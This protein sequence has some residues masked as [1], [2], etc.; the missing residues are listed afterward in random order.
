MLGIKAY[1]SIE[2]IPAKVDL[3][4][5]CTPA[6]TRAAASSASASQAGVKGAVV[7]SAGF[8]E[9]G[10]EG[11]KLW[12][13]DAHRGAQGQDA[14]HRPELPGHPEPAHRRERHVRQRH[15]EARQ[16][17]LPV[18]VGA[19]R[20]AVLDWSFREQVGFSALRFH[21]LDG[22]CGLGRP[23]RLLRQ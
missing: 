20:T 23:D 9:L 15:G 14:H 18:A 7:I 6:P 1:P 8:A 12:R 11:K 5:V 22:R 16:R 13:A 17:G 10:E 21:R 2:E 19:L 4:V 3:I